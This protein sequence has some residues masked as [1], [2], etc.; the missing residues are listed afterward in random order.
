MARGSFRNRLIAA[1]LGAAVLSAGMP[2][3]AQ[4]RTDASVFLEAVKKKDGAKAIEMLREPGTTV[5]DSRDLTTGETGLHIAAQR[6][7]LTWLG[8]LLGKKANP[9]VADKKGLTP[10][11]IATQA[12]FIDGVELLAKSGARVDEPNSTGETPLIYAVHSRD[13][14]LVRVL[15]DAGADPD[16]ADNSGRSA[17]DYARLQGGDRPI[18]EAIEQQ[19]TDGE[20]ARI[21][22]PSL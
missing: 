8:F 21:Y 6:R 12:R 14:P 2:A 13:L 22:G 11:L 1:V 17:R 15:L 4:M 5:I 18:L 16:R 9:N 10:L 19:K 20:S 3:A 7:D